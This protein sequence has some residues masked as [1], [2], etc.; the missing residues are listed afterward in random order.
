MLV[1]SL[2]RSNKRLVKLVQ[3][4][5]RKTFHN[6]LHQDISRMKN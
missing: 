1:I 3:R 5:R 2:K 4:L 6:T